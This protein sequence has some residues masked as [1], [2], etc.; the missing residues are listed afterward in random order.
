MFATHEGCEAWGPLSR[1]PGM[2]GARVRM[3]DFLQR[4][5]RTET[6]YLDTVLCRHIWVSPGQMSQNPDS[7]AGIRAYRE[8][9]GF[10]PSR[11][12]PCLSLHIPFGSFVA[13]IEEYHLGYLRWIGF[14]AQTEKTA[15]S[16]HPVNRICCS[17]ARTPSI[18]RGA[19]T[20]T[21]PGN[22]GRW[23]PRDMLY[24]R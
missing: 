21:A 3:K 24:P 18:H 20:R 12:A 13:S 23:R 14:P 19:D 1:Q 22:A 8:I 4:V 10:P 16:S 2:S 6:V 11:H 5:A 15:L 9:A 17:R 7:T